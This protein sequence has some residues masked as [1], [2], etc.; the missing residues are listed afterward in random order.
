MDDFQDGRVCLHFVWRR[1][2]QDYL[3]RFSLGLPTEDQ[4]REQAVDGDQLR[5]QAV[6]GR[7]RRFSESKLRKLEDARGRAEHRQLAL[8]LKAAFNAVEAGIIQPEQLFLSFLVGKDGR[9]VGE[10]ALPR[11]PKL[12]SGGASLLLLGA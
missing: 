12:L 4:L 7:S 2:D 10:V 6:D 3:A 11:L 9:T 8:L 5:E 1:E